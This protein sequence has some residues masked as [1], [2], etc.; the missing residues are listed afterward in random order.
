MIRSL[1]LVTAAALA[2]SAPALAQHQ[3][4]PAQHPPEQAEPLEGH[5]EHQPAQPQQTPSSPEHEH[6]EAAPAHHEHGQMTHGG[7]MDAHRHA[8]MMANMRGLYG[9]YPMGRDASGTSWQPDVSSHGGVHRHAGD[10]MLMGHAMLNGVYA[11]SDSPRGDEKAFLAG[12]IMGSA[13]RDIGERG[14][15]NLRAMLSPDPFMGADGYPLLFAAGES[16]DGVTGLVD[17]QHPH[18]LFM[19]LA[20]SYTHRIGENSA[21][22]LYGGLPGEPAFGPPAFMHRMSA[23][24]SPEAPITH[25]WFDSTHI[26]FGVI[27]AGMT[28]RNW[29]LEGSRFRGR[30]PDEER[31]DIES[32]ELDSTSLRV[33]WNPSENWSLQA[34]WAD[35]ASPEALEPDEDEER[36][37]VSGIYTR[38][39]GVDAFYSVTVAFANKERSDGVSLDAWLAEAAWHPNDRWTWFAR[40]EAIETDELE[41]PG[42]GPIRDV[43]RL[44]VGAIRDWRIN[45]NAVFGVGALVQQHL[46]PDELEGAYDGDPVGAMGFVRLKIG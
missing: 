11:W 1:T 6:E 34:S 40:G 9:P 7:S 45:E 2:V 16:A 32:G 22:F 37:S 44:S 4:D 5:E 23:M 8:A 31:Y 26:T 12:M 41:P 27:T 25:H 33:S 35:I 21:V 30:E 18:D 38:P 28:H 14:T 19:E 46:A 24:D 10:W 43:A 39:V 3:H 13:R 29:K 17:R 42:H 36:W 20:A 15:L